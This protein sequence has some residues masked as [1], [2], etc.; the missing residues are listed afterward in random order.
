MQRG[1]SVIPKSSSRARVEE[2][3]RLVTL[4]EAEMEEL[5]QAHRTIGPLRIADH[6]QTTRGEKDGK[7]TF[8]GWTNEDFGW[9]DAEGNWLL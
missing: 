4:T 9:E 1:I 8:M 3:L 5:N 2:N 6:I 7:P